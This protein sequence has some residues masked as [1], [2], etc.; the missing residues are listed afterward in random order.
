MGAAD[1]Q[2]LLIQIFKCMEPEQQ[3][4]IFKKT[5]YDQKTDE[6]NKKYISLC[7]KFGSQLRTTAEYCNSFDKTCKRILIRQGKYETEKIRK[8]DKNWKVQFKNDG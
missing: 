7:S 2:K 5:D 4:E 3:L 8:K 1:S 6:L